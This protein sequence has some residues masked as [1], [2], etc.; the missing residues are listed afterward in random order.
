MRGTGSRHRE[1]LDICVGQ[2]GRVCAMDAGAG[3]GKTTSG[4]SAC[5]YLNELLSLGM[6]DEQTSQVSWQHV[7]KLVQ[8]ILDDHLLLVVLDRLCRSTK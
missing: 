5:T 4:C 2:L 1:G 6:V 8:V 3:C 7:E